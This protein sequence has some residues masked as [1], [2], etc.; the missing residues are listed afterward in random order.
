MNNLK[1]YLPHTIILI[2]ALGSVGYFVWQSAGIPGR[3][4]F[5]GGNDMI[6]PK[7]PNVQICEERYGIRGGYCG[8]SRT[9]VLPR[10]LIVGDSH[11]YHYF[12]SLRH[13]VEK[14][15]QPGAV[16]IFG[17]GGCP[18]FYGVTRSNGGIP[19][20]CGEQ[21]EKALK[22]AVSLD[23]IKIVLMAAQFT[24]Y[25]D[26]LETTSLTASST[27][28]DQIFKKASADT[29]NSL[30][31]TGKR[32]IIMLQVPTL[33]IDPRGC[34]GARPIRLTPQKMSECKVSLD[35][36]EKSRQRYLSLLLPQIREIKGLEVFDPIKYL[37]DEENCPVFVNQRGRYYDS[38]HV[39]PLNIEWLGDHFTF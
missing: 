26:N 38:F 35:S 19:L 29:F 15:S 9:D 32:V 24:S 27:T 18:P 14:N 23:S 39:L 36:V 10:I 7:L 11:A 28:G 12:W 5:T 21:I 3:G 2:A 37:C 22:L 13:Y 33:D 34:P 8:L 6:W 16:A 17:Q 1:K 31:K 4:G 25:T 30:V 20:N